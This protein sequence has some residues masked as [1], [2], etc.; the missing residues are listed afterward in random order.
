MRSNLLT[1]KNGIAKTLSGSLKLNSSLRALTQSRRGN[2][3]KNHKI[4][5]QRQRRCN[6]SIQKIFGNR[7]DFLQCRQNAYRRLLKP[8]ILTGLP[9]FFLSKK[10][11]NDTVFSFRLPEIIFALPFL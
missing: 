8:A 3:V 11:R 1:T 5:Y 7:Q 2:P 9:R 6:G 10:S 4:F